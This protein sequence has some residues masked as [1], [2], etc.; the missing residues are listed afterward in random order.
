MTTQQTQAG[1]F[2]DAARKSSERDQLFLEM[3]RDGLTKRELNENI[4][5]RPSLWGRYKGWLNKLPA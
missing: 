4:Q 3:V 5:R 1:M 2:Y